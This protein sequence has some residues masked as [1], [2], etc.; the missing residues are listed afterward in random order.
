MSNPYSYQSQKGR[1]EILER[2]PK[3]K[4][5]PLVGSFFLQE[6]AKVFRALPSLEFPINSAGELIH[7]LGGE[8]KMLQMENT[9][10]NPLRMITY[11]PAYYFP[12]ASMENLVEKM[13]ELIRANKKKVDIPSVLENVRKQLPR[14]QYPIRNAAE[15]LKI[16]GERKQYNFGRST[17]YPAEMLKRVPEGL[18]PI[19]SQ[20]DFEKKVLILLHTRPLIASD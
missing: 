11:M 16:L 17:V 6:I 2:L 1:K 4:Y 9:E 18:F 3:M 14:M 15:F 7:K 20:E 8:E 10:V 5:E 13:A 19:T 12:I